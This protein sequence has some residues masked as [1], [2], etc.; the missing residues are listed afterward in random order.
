MKTSIRRCCVTPKNSR[1]NNS[2]A[3]AFLFPL[4]PFVATL[5]GAQYSIFFCFC[6]ELH[7]SGLATTP[8]ETSLSSSPFLHNHSA[9]GIPICGINLSPDGD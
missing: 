3:F 2:S 1:L 7:V 5:S 8:T 9:N 6:F 4:M